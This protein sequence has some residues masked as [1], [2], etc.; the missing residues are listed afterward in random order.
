MANKM[1]NKNAMTLEYDTVTLFG[2]V[3][4]GASGAVASYSGGGIASVA[5][6][7]T[8]GQYT[9]T[10]ADKYSRVLHVDA[11]VYGAALSGAT[12]CQLLMDPATMQAD[13]AGNKEIVIQCADE[14][15]VAVNPAEDEAIMLKLVLRNTSVGPYDV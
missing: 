8:A 5:K 7:A 1:F 11:K 6:E 14:A 10:L 4:I 3:V 9:I 2:N 12:T 15:G 13:V